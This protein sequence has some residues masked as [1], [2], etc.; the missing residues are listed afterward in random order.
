MI[1]V[2]YKIYDKRS[3]FDFDIVNFLFWMAMFHVVYISQLKIFARVFSH[4]EDL[5]L[6]INV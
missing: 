1:F 6:E 2:S 4:V 3:D 5:M